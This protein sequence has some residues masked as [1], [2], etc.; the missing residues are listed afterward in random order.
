MTPWPA[1]T[2]PTLPGR[3]LPVRLWDTSA[4]RTA[5]STTEPIARMYV[6]GITPYDATH[7]GHAATYVAFD[8]LNR[9]WQDGGHQ[10]RY[11]QN[12]TDI[13]D[14]LLER[15]AATGVDWRELAAEQTRLFTED[16]ARLR[17]L[18]PDVYLGAVET[19]PLVVD[20]VR[21]LLAGSQ[22]YQL[23]GDVY[24]AVRS[25][26]RFGSVSRLGEKVMHELFAERGGDLD[27][28]GKKDPLDALLWRA[29]REGEPAWD[30]GTLGRGR[31]GWHIEC[32]AIALH[33]LGMSFDVQGGGCDLVFPHHEMTA[34]HAQALT[35]K[36]PYAQVYAHAGMVG[37]A[38]HKMSKS[39]GNL[40]L[41][42]Q[43]CARGA[44]PMA[45]RLALLDHHYR[46]DWEWTDADLDGAERRLARWR[47]ATRLL[48]GPDAQPLLGQVRERMADD[49]D[50]PGA[51]RAVDEWVERALTEG[52][53]IPR[54]PALAAK[55]SD[56]LLGVKLT[57]IR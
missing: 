33:E 21:Q 55:V 25:D 42:S 30:G 53:T 38:G 50:A 12:V 49:L 18:P 24:F 8:L 54:S 5:P 23:D 14:P 11:V 3:G 1:P 17:V 46:H 16:M 45:I 9:A 20:A 56:A 4:D 27:R 15:A 6:C 36:W 7:I 37:Y 51:L 19:I 29:E 26:P 44:D 2:L 47:E 34:A 13:D 41:V 43:L 22:A 52:G 57:T 40:V 35:G 39:R 31:P 48:R 10:V 28:P 32:A